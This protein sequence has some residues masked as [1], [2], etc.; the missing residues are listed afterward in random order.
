MSSDVV[1]VVNMKL[2]SLLGR[3]SMLFGIYQITCHHILA[4]CNLHVHHSE[5]LESHHLHVCS[6]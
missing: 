3:D 1:M 5:N 6:Y 2:Y 4:E